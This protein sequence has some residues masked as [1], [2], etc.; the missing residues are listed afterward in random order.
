MDQITSESALNSAISNNP[1]FIVMFTAPWSD[2]G[3]LT[4]SAIERVGARY[5]ALYQAWVSVDENP[6]LAQKWGYTSIPATVGYKNGSKVRDFVA[7]LYED[8]RVEDFIRSVL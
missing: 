3:Q 7:P 2:F 8:E 4:K 5:P 6:E 1:S